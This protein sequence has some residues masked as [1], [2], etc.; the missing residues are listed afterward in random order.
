MCLVKADGQN[1][2]SRPKWPQ[3]KLMMSY[4]GMWTMCLPK[5]ALSVCSGLTY[6]MHAANQCIQ[7]RT[8]IKVIKVPFAARRLQCEAL[9]NLTCN[10]SLEHSHASLNNGDTV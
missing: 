2:T 10:I 1:E 3:N 4:L 8:V 5:S 9:Q 7:H 6:H